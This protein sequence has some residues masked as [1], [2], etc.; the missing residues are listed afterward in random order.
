MQRKLYFLLLRTDSEE[1]IKNGHYSQ[2]L[3][4]VESCLCSVEK[5]YFYYN[6][7]FGNNKFRALYPPYSF[8]Y[9]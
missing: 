1:A 8:S 9:T 4:R 5:N 3:H 6:F 7:P 2:A